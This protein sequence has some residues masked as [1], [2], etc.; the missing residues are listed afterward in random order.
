MN[1]RL[2]QAIRRF[3]PAIFAGALLGAIEVGLVAGTRLELFLSIQEFARFWLIVTCVAISLQL[4][5]AS[6]TA[7]LGQWLTRLAPERFH[8][9]VALLTGV[10]P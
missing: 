5:F 3:L 2:S 4:L 7:L 1:Q 9:A 8:V 10:A 6:A